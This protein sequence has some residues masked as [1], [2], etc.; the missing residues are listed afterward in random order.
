MT[1]THEFNFGGE[2]IRFAIERTSRRKTVAISVGFDGVR[3]LAP[4][5]LD[6]ARVIEIVRKKGPWVLRKQAGYR[7]LG[8]VPI[9]REFVSGET[10]HYLG[11]PYRLRIVPDADAVISRIVARGSML[12]A[13]VLP[14]M[15]ALIQRSAVRSALRHWYRDKAKKHFPERA[16]IMAETLGVRRPPIHVV[17][18]SKR[19]GSC[20]ARGHIRLNWRLVMAPV[21]LIDYVIAHETCHILE[22]NHSRRFWRALETIMP[23][24]EGRLRKLDRLGHKFIW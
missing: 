18:Q 10:Y 15:Q 4:S 7:E 8:G 17:D 22:H 16:R 9:D 11:R 5:D 6:D 19:W 23:D 20:D 1:A 12:I 2:F 21:S 14:D 3:V 13:P 24:Y